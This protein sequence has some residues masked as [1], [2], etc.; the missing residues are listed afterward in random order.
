M[1]CFIIE[2]ILIGP[3]STQTSNNRYDVVH[4]SPPTF[5]A[6][7]SPYQQEN[8]DLNSTEHIY[9]EEHTVSDEVVSGE[10]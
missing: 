7:T 8:L 9:H 5:V 10:V 6:G 4:T 2:Y 3:S 1:H